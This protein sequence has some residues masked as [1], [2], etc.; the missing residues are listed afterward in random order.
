MKAAPRPAQSPRPQ[1]SARARRAA[2]S[3]RADGHTETV[4]VRDLKASL[5]AYLRRVHKGESLLVTDR[6]K[7]VARLSPPDIP[8]GILR[9]MREGKLTWS[10][11]K[12]DFSQLPRVRLR[13]K[14]PT[15]SDMIIAERHED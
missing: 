10:G 8:E 12:P 11:R 5:S 2:V 9:M 1:A 6:G 7:P 3:A 13:G 4:G 14:G 15:L